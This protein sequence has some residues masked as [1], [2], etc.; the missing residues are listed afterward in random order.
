MSAITDIGRRVREARTGRGLTQKALADS[1]GLARQT[2]AQLEQGTFSDLGIRKIERVLHVLGLGLQIKP[3]PA[4]RQ[5]PRL[6]RLFD[7][8]ARARRTD[9]LA[10]ARAALAALR[11]RRI[12]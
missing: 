6:Q 7:A 8:R 9:A 1:C 4:S 10:R 12:A 2:I 3:R 11:K 5:R